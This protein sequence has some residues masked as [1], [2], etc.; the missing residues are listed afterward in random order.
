MGEA[1]LVGQLVGHC[2]NRRLDQLHLSPSRIWLMFFLRYV[3][4]LN[5]CPDS[6]KY[7]GYVSMKSM[8]SHYWGVFSY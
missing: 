1:I 4:E 3:L 6:M 7:Y 8:P 2:G 5:F